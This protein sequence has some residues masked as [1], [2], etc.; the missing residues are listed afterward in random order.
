MPR[1]RATTISAPSTPKQ[2]PEAPTVSASG[3]NSSAPNEPAS[4]EVKYTAAKL[5]A[6]DRRLEHR[7]HHVQEE[8]VEGDVEDAVVQEAAGDDPPVLVLVDDRRAEQRALVE[9][10]AAATAAVDASPPAELGDEHATLIAISA[11][12]TTGVAGDRAGSS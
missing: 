2:A 9:H 6:P 10:R 5:S 4:S 1:L 8:H 7:P 3:W 11:C 12:V